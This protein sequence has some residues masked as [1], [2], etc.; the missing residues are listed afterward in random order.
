MFQ[1]QKEALSPTPRKRIF[2]GPRSPTPPEKNFPGSPVK[3][4]LWSL[5]ADPLKILNFLWDY[6]IRLYLGMK[7]SLQN[8]SG[9]I[10]SS[11][12]DFK[13]FLSIFQENATP[14][15]CNKTSVRKIS[16]YIQ[17]YS[18]TWPALQYGY[19]KKHD[20]LRGQALGPCQQCFWQAPFINN[21]S[22]M[23]AFVIKSS[24]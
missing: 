13:L 15:H 11:K 14:N 4:F 23:C 6:F 7:I 17:D 18:K 2:L 19:V 3:Y 24:I 9:D 20:Y 5:V 12:T 16:D 10:R 21:L 22:Q 8:L 1:G